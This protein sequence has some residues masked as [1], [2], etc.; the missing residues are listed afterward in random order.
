MGLLGVA[1]KWAMTVLV[2][3]VKMAALMAAPMEH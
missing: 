1:A 2:P 3:V